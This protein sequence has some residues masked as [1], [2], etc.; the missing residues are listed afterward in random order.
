MQRKILNQAIATVRG[1]L[2]QSG[3]GLAL[4]TKDG[5]I[6]LELTRKRLSPI[7]A[8][9]CVILAG[10]PRFSPR[11]RKLQSLAVVGCGFS[12][13]RSP[14][15]LRMSGRIFAVND[16]Q[17]VL[18]VSPKRLD[19]F[20]VPIQ[21]CLPNAEEGQYW[22][23][24]C[25]LEKGLATLIDAEKLRGAYVPPKLKRKRSRVRQKVAA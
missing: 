22:R 16:K 19:S 23:L 17:I 9:T 13:Q 2:V 7:T 14:G 1:E 4:L 11:T 25:S 21:G 18:E 20:F 5:R 15:C 10:Y 24:E 12:I 6:D 8:R 3:D